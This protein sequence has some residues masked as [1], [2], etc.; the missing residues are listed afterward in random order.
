LLLQIHEGGRLL[1][2]SDAGRLRLAEGSH[3]LEFVS[4]PLGVRFEHLIHITPGALVSVDIE[5]PR[6]PISLNAKPWAD[7]WIDGVRAG[8]TPLDD[9]V[10]P[11]GV[12]QVEFRHPQ[13]GT[14]RMTVVVS[15]KTAV[16]VAVDMRVP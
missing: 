3:T 16:R 8:Q 9:L 10:E 14:K 11:V 12:H 4:E 6:V 5:P 2:V 1:G 13:L 7:V 15:L